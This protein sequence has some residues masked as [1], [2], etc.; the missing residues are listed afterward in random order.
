MEPRPVCSKAV[1]PALHLAPWADAARVPISPVSAGR[2]GGLR[3]G[4]MMSVNG[5]AEAGDP[6]TPTL[7]ND[8]RPT[9]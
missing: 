8:D 9:D 7:P 6:D 4:T 2:L 1:S 5:R 3:W